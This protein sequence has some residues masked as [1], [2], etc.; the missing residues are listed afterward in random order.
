M[1]R[2]VIRQLA[3][4]T[5]FQMEVGQLTREEAIENIEEMVEDLKEE[6]FE[7]VG[8]ELN[9][10]GITK[11]N[12]Q[13]QLDGFY[14]ELVDGVLGNLKQID[15]TIEENLYDWSLVRLNKVDKA[16]LRLATYEMK[17]SEETNHSVVINEAIELTKEF[18]DTGDGKAKSFNNRVLDQIKKSLA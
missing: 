2:H 13:F 5:L 3:V 6:A 15:E 10:Q 11:I 18:S 9:G 8:E 17:Y 1:I 14:F 12:S 4:Q 16:I 7:I